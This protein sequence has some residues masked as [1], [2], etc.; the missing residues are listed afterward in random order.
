MD[1]H[2]VMLLF[3]SLPRAVRFAKPNEAWSTGGTEHKTELSDGAG[4][5]SGERQISPFELT[6]S[7]ERLRWSAAACRRHLTGKDRLFLS[8]APPQ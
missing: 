8:C 3:A 7:R 5:G 1:R 2:N 4:E 6:A